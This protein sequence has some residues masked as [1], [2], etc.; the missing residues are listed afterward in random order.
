MVLYNP[1]LVT[2]QITSRRLV[3]MIDGEIEA[4]TRMKSTQ[5]EN[6][7]KPSSFKYG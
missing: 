6:S 4:Q 2:I 1:A 5:F 7:I 3:E